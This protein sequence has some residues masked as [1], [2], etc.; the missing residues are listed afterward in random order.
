MLNRRNFIGALSGLAALCGLRLKATPADY[1]EVLKG[2]LELRPAGKGC[3]GTYQ[4]YVVNAMNVSGRVIPPDTPVY[5]TD[6][7][8]VTTRNPSN[9]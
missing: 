5:W 8:K 3:Y 6:D 4:G 1:G 7:G 2:T 9:A